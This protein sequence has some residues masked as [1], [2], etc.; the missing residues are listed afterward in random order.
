MKDEAEESKDWPLIK[1]EYFEEAARKL[2]IPDY[3]IEGID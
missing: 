3:R 1:E 2:G